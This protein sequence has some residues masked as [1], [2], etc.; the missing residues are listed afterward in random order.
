MNVLMTNILGVT[1]I[2]LRETSILL[3][4]SRRIAEHETEDDSMTNI[5]EI[6]DAITSVVARVVDLFD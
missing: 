3:E 1:K 2:S 6:K 5:S 4:E